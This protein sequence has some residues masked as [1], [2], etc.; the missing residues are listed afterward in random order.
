MSA[1]IFDAALTTTFQPSQPIQFVA[2][3]ITIDFE[4]VITQATT[5][6]LW[7]F[8]YTDGDPTSAGT[9]T[10]WFRETAEENQGGG[11][12]AMPVATRW[13]AVQGSNN[14]PAPLPVGTHRMSMQFLRSHRYYRIQTAVEAGGGNAVLRAWNIFGDIPQSPG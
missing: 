5:R 11:N 6:V 9:N 13:L 3:K 10:L 1:K 14:Q 2:E 4:A 12:V 8:E 7:Y